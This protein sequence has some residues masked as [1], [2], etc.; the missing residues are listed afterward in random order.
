MSSI[1]ESYEI[2]K[3]WL[4]WTYKNENFIWFH[5]IH[6]KPTYRE[7]WWVKTWNSISKAH[8]FNALDMNFSSRL[9]KDLF[10]G[11][12]LL[13]FGILHWKMKKC[14]Q[15]MLLH[16]HNHKLSWTL[17]TV[18]VVLIMLWTDTRVCPTWQSHVSL[19]NSAIYN[20]S[21]CSLV[22]SSPRES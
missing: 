20:P 3:I 7:T 13:E 2:A 8:G 10:W 19:Y 11:L 1:T 17:M 9:N 16:S 22:P 12:N 4:F 15:Y 6:H 5:L 18:T 14:L 21:S